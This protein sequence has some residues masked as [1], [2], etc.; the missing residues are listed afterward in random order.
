MSE[1]RHLVAKP[2]T[3][4]DFAPYG[5][6]FV[7]PGEGR[8]NT[9]WDIP[10]FDRAKLRLSLSRRAPATLPF[11][12]QIMERHSRSQ[13][14]FIPLQIGRFLV[15]V[16]A[17]DGAPMPKLERA[18][19]FIGQAGQALNYRVGTWHHPFTVLDRE[20]EYASLMFR[21]GGPLDEEFVDL[22]RPLLIT[23]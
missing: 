2:L 8:E 18:V 4:A 12:T 20:A 7:A 10:G 17:N 15:I 1:P 16:A 23:V 6:V 13:Q 5:E 11:S 9:D 19:A 22:P 21:D 14:I 3:A